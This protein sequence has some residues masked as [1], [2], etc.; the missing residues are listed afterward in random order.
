MSAT[1]LSAAHLDYLQRNGFR[2]TPLSGVPSRTSAPP[3]LRLLQRVKGVGRT[4]KTA[5]SASEPVLRMPSEDVLIGLYGYKIPVA[6]LVCGDEHGV[7]LHTGTW[8]PAQREKTKREV[9]G[10]RQRLLEGLLRS[11]Y[12]AVDLDSVEASLPIAFPFAGFVLGNPT[13]KP[14]DVQDVTLP[15][16]RLIRSL[17]G[18]RWAFLVL[19]E[20][21]AESVTTELRANVINEMRVVQTAVEAT[22]APSPLAQQYTELL[23]LLLASLTQ[24]LAAGMW[25]SAVYLLGDNTGY[26]RLAST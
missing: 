21:V 22:R 9:L 10:D 24:G 11:T 16:D 12:P 25:R 26:Y 17:S 4:E 7:A 3:E 23:Q 20:P 8:S 13:A 6:F 19:A 5:S 2:P 1:A 14:P 18:T 15:L